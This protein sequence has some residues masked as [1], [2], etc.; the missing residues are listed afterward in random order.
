MKFTTTI[1]LAISLIASQASA[2]LRISCSMFPV[3]DFTRELTAGHA[4]VSLI[5]KPGIEPHD[6]EP[7]PKDIKAIHD[8][9]VFVFTGAQMEHWAGRI[10]DSLTGTRIADASE[11]ITL[12]DNDPHIWLDLALAQKMVR[13][14][15]AVLCSADP[16]NAQAYSSN[17]E[18]YCA[19]LAELNAKFISLKKTKPLVFIGEFSYGYFV[20]C[21]GFDYVS[22]YEGENEPGL[23]RMAA[24]I[25]H[26][27][28]NNSRFVLADD[29]P[30]PQ[31]TLSI[32]EQTGAEILTFSSVHNVRPGKTFL[33]IMADNL[34]A[35]TSFLND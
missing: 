2:G 16:E 19:K 10:A 30:L 13:N 12:T 17:A 32:S 27:R 20:R 33:E 22:A 31:V 25:R 6:F 9:D 29:P 24:V 23:K 34:A 4:E 5:L 15:S 21:Y 14:I 18:A 8:S 1:F 28:D 26:I 11:G 7:S 3:Y 35:I